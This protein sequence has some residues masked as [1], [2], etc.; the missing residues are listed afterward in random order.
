MALET[1]K[2]KNNKTIPTLEHNN[3]RH[4]TNTEKADLFGKILS[5]IFKEE[6]NPNFNQPHKDEVEAFIQIKGNAL[7]TTKEQDEIYD[8]MFSFNELEECLQTLRKKSAPGIDQVSNKSLIN[9]TNK[10]KL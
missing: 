2:S 7:F 5:D 1:K 9:L 8:S 10:G 3:Q 6:P 4:S